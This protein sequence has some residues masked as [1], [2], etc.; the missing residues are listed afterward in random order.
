MKSILQKSFYGM[1]ALAFIATTSCDNSPKKDMSIIPGFDLANLDTTVSP[2][3]DFF[4]YSTGGWQKANPIPETDSRWG[5]FNILYEQ[6]QD[7][8]KGLIKDAENNKG[9]KGSDSQLIGDFYKS[10]MD[11]MGIEEAGLKPLQSLE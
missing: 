1:L 7:K 8:I 9:E 6:G 2:T 4:Q 10:A 3:D 5:A 11:S